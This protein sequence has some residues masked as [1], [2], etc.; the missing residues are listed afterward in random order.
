MVLR[1]TYQPVAEPVQL[2]NGQITSINPT[3]TVSLEID[4][5]TMLRVPVS[6][7]I[8]PV[9]AWVRVLTTPYS[10]LVLGTA[11][12]PIEPI[13]DTG[14]VALSPYAVSGID[15]VGSS[16]VKR[17]GDV[18]T[19]T[20]EAL[21]SFPSGSPLTPIA[22]DLPEIFRPSTR[23]MFGA[24]WAGSYAGLVLARPNGTIDIGNRS[25]APWTAPQFT[26]TYLV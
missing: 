23:N 14:W 26:V 1:R 15:I 18:V 20:G 10:A 16:V 3:G 7:I 22:E 12:E 21:G 9:G 25:G 6:G 8:P 11:T 5:G 13:E 4:G 19:I 17:A 24:A 2:R